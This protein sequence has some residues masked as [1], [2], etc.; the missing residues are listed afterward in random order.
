V[1]PLTI[2]LEDLDKTFRDKSFAK[3]M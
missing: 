1:F 2:D 3:R